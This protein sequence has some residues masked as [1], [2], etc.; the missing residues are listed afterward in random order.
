MLQA[1]VAD[2]PRDLPPSRRSCSARVRE[3]QSVAEVAA[4]LQLVRASSP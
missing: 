3:P 2:I 4:K 1:S